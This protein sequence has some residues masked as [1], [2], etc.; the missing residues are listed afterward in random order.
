MNGFV[1]ER[2]RRFT[3]LMRPLAMRSAGRAGTA[4]AVIR[5][6]GRRS[7]RAFAT[8]VTVV[9]HGDEFVV[10]LP[11]GERTDWLRNVLASGRATVVVRG[12]DHQVDDPRVVPLAEITGAFP[13]RERVALRLFGV[14][15]ALR[16]HRA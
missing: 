7:G 2:L 5:H 9:E 12:E 15:T 10:A 14:R 11:Y 13:A 6:V 16:L 3:K 4:T 8:P 1:Q